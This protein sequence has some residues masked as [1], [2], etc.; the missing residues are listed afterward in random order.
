MGLWNKIFGKRYL[1]WEEYKDK[2][3]RIEEKHWQEAKSPK[4]RVS[5]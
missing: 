3:N 5:K 1:D 4:F 2:I